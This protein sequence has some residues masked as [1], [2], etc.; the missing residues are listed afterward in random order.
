MK[1]NEKQ[2][3]KSKVDV[4]PTDRAET[5]TALTIIAKAEKIEAEE[6][7]AEIINDTAKPAMNLEQT[8]KI[9]EQLY[10]KKRYRDRLELSIDE[11]ESFKIKHE[12]EDL[13]DRSYYTGC[14]IVIKDDERGE[15]STKNPVIIGDVVKFLTQ[16]FIE[17]RTE[18]ES[19]I[20][21][22]Y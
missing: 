21:L 11:L 9:V 6:T 17:R 8:M 1:Q 15:F 4:T 16:K 22:P 12:Q 20:V 7:K 19:S 14:Q 18:I 2:A 10:T 5:K 13:D 3:V